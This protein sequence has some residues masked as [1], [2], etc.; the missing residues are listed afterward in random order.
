MLERLSVRGLGIIDAVDLQLDSGFAALT[1]ETGAGKSLLVESLKLLAGQRAQSEMV[2]TGDDRLQVE[3]VFSVAWETPLASVLED[4]G[5]QQT[6]EIVLRREVTEGGRGRAWLNDVTVTAGAL[7]KMAPHLLAIHGQHEQHGLADS[8]VQ[9]RLVDDFGTPQ[10]LLVETRKRHDLWQTAADEL[11]RL[12]RQHANR[13][14][15]LDTISFQLQEIDGVA[16]TVGEDEDL[17]RRRQLLRHASRIADLT[18][19]LLDSLSDGETSA[20]DRLARAEREITDIAECGV[21]LDGGVER[22][23]EARV[24]VEEVV[25]EVQTLVADTKA[26]PGELEATE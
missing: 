23:V 4:L 8:S 19:S 10:E 5:I 9:R 25:R 15:R 17:A 26:H 7:Q 3:G 13:R 22:L 18:S 1:G 24:H 16:P 20:V 21:V 11:E 12:R 14:D 6:D 2:R